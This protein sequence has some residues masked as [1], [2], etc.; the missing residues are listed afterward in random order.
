MLGAA[1]APLGATGVDVE[2]ATVT[3]A[4]MKRLVSWDFTVLL[5]AV[6]HGETP[7][8]RGQHRGTRACAFGRCL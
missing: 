2:Q 8:N 5:C 6:P 3:R 1:G 7:A 4:R